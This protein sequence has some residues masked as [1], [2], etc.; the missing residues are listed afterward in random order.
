MSYNSSKGQFAVKIRVV[1]FKEAFADCG[2]I[3]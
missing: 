1:N 3:R 2:N